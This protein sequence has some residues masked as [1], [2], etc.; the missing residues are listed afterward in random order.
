MNRFK[1]SSVTLSNLNQNTYHKFAMNHSMMLYE[2]NALYSFIPKNACSTMRLSVAKANGCIDSIEQGHWIHANNGTF[3]ATLGEAIKADYTFTILRCPFYRLA[4]VFIDK[5][6]AK[7]LSAWQ[8]RSRLGETIELDNLT[9]R[10][11]V[12]FLTKP[13]ILKMNIHWRPQID[14]MIYEKY[15][16]YFSVENFKYAVSALKTNIN[17]DVIDAR[18]LTNHGTDGFAAVYDKLYADVAAF[19]IAVMKQEGKCPSYESMYDNEL[20]QVVSR[21][22][23]DDI[24]L[25]TEMCNVEH[26]LNVNDVYLNNK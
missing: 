7:E 22:Y 16:D 4:S 11:F 23:H 2:A 10:E 6:V 25:Y 18:K 24:Q 19:D 17:L 21:L 13:G 1:Y 3:N 8:F 9:F 26:L 14:F 20:Y 12:T 5:F 15:S